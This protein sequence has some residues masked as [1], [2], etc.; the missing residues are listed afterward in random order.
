MTI[1]KDNAPTSREIWLEVEDGV[2][3]MVQQDLG[4]ACQIMTGEDEYEREVSCK[5][6][7]LEA[8]LRI[9]G[10]AA[11]LDQLSK[12]FHSSDSIDRFEVYL[13]QHGIRYDMYSD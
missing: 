13:S 7:E 12:M 9:K 3:R 5:L 1:Y 6:K 2:V 11:V 10:A 4:P 8:V